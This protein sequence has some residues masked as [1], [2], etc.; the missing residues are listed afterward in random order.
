[1]RIARSTAR[2]A[3]FAWLACL[4]STAAAAACTAQGAADHPRLVELY[5]SEGCSSCPPAEQWLSTLRDKPGYVGLE[6]HV[7]YWDS[8]EWRDPYSDPRFSARQKSIAARHA[9]DGIFTPQVLVDGRPWAN[10]SQS[11]EPKAPAAADVKL[12]LA[13]TPTGGTLHATIDGGAA[14]AHEH[15][16]MFLALTENGLA[17]AITGGENEG[18][19]LLHDHV[20]RAFAGPFALG[21]AEADLAAP[22]GMRLERSAVVAFVQDE[23][24]GD[25]VQVVRQRVAACTPA[26]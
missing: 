19:M 18:A 13:L 5:T 1:M 12:A 22:K 24:S 2:L 25:I 21:H 14:G 3:G 8:N 20:V 15:L 9:H 7:D 23:R 11:A 17:N 16:Q 10:W 6:F 4:A 26:S